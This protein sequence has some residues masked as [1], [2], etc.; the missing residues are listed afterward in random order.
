V[1]TAYV[2][3][4]GLARIILTTVSSQVASFFGPFSGSQIALSTSR[5]KIRYSAHGSIVMVSPT[6]N[7][8]SSQR[9][10]I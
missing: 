2:R 4:L 10:A 8:A 1:K 6:L 5:A 3:M 7:L 9:A